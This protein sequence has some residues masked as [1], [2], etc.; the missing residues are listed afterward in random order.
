MSYG[1]GRRWRSQFEIVAG[2]GH[3]GGVSSD[4]PFL[5]RS[6]TARYR[7]TRAASGRDEWRRRGDERVECFVDERLCARFL[8]GSLG[9]HRHPRP[10]N[11]AG[12]TSR[13]SYW[14]AQLD[15]DPVILRRALILGVSSYIWLWLVALGRLSDGGFQ[16]CREFRQ[17]APSI[18]GHL[19]L[20]CRAVAGS[21]CGHGFIY[22]E[23]ICFDVPRRA[24]RFLR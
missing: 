2:W 4:Q 18:L 20:T 24:Y 21:C 6:F 7:A 12:E 19:A 8:T 5:S 17:P 3:G 1:K 10:D 11:E 14:E 22:S 16:R 23:L 15:G 13:R 9:Y